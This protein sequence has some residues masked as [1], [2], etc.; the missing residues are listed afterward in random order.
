MRCAHHSRDRTHIHTAHFANREEGNKTV[1]GAASI[2]EERIQLSMIRG[3]FENLP[4]K[5][6]PLERERKCMKMEK[7]EKWT[8]SHLPIT[9]HDSQAPRVWTG[10]RIYS[11]T[12]CSGWVAV[13]VSSL[14]C[15]SFSLML[16]M[17]MRPR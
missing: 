4:N 11:W 12:S 9:P 5:G 15:S 7:I 14:L 8:G 1:R 17:A 3:E 6:K 16:W 2:V 10:P 13:C